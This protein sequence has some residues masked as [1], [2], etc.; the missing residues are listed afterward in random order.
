MF[1][2][3]LLGEFDEIVLV[4]HADEFAEP[5]LAPDHQRHV[6]LH[7]GADRKGHDPGVVM[8]GDVADLLEH[9]FRKALRSACAVV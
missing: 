5:L 9:V 3:L 1:L 2:P 6:V 8:P 4:V 7:G